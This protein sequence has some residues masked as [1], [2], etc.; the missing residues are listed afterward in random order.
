MGFIGNPSGLAIN[1]SE[2]SCGRRCCSIRLPALQQVETIRK[3]IPAVV[4]DQIAA[5]LGLGKEALLDTDVGSQEVVN[6]L[7]CIKWGVYA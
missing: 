3:G 6:L 4:F 1:L 2:S 7:H 5:A